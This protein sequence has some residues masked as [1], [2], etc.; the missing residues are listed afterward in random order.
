MK[1]LLFFVLLFFI[2]VLFVKANSISSIS[3]DI[4]IDDNG[5]ALVT[6]TWN[7]NVN[8]GTEGYHPYFNVGNSNFIMESA[9][10]DGESYE[11]IYDW[12]INKS[13]SEKAYK[14]GIYKT[15][16]EIDLCYGL[17]S[18]GMHT[19]EFKYKITN[20]VLGLADADMV[21]WTLF[22]YDFSAIPNNVYIKI[23]SNFEYNSNL[24]VWG[25]GNY[26]GTAYVYDGYI[27]MNSPDTLSKDQYMTILVKFPKGTFNTTNISNN[28]FEYY[29]NMAN[30]GSKRY[31]NKKGIKTLAH[32]VE[33]I[34]QIL[35]YGIP[36]I[37]GVIVAIN[38]KRTRDIYDF[39]ITGNKIR[40]DVPNFRD[41]PCNK[42]LF[43][44]Y[45]IA[46]KYNISTKKEN[47]L[48]ALLLKWLKDGNVKVEKIEKQQFFGPKIIDNIIFIKRPENIE[49]EK[50]MYDWMYEASKDGKLEENE[51]K[52]WCKKS[53]SAILNWF[54]DI[55]DYEQKQLINEGKIKIEVDDTKHCK[56]TRYVVDPSLM[57]EAETIQG[58]KKYLKKFTLI[59]EKEPIEVHLWNEYL[60]FAQMFGIAK[61]VAKQF[62]K[63][64]PEISKYMS[65]YGYDYNTM[66]FL[67]NVSNTGM[68]SANSAKAR[69]ESY[70]SG[71]GGF[72][73]GGGGGGSF[74]GGGG[75]GGFR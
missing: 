73:S 68:K 10:M 8:S 1:K 38:Y 47:M 4:F 72:S 42:D 12:D 62:E 60:I 44:A 46:N 13:L 43:R 65:E 17:S 57:L 20:F 35:L 26:G 54:D 41:I 28:E 64:Y 7:A 16:N 66:Y 69:A 55:I 56:T 52:K 27:E 30:E 67:Y 24:D 19:Y 34:C 40:D 75:G 61:E 21:Y 25:Y 6:E 22:P 3:M 2:P 48:G 45:F 31:K 37:I 71:G 39:G 33:I 23:Y 36:V 5:D 32:F 29:H 70:S 15:G 49:L 11:I 58:L 74:G 50:E 9:S 63:L 14:A 18:Y 59:K 51:F 53:Y